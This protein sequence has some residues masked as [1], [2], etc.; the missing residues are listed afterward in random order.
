MG[1]GVSIG[2]V[3][4]NMFGIAGGVTFIWAGAN[5][6]GGFII[7][8]LNGSN[9]AIWQA[10]VAPD[11]QGRVFAVRRWIA[12]ITA[13]VGMLIAGPM[14]DWLME[15]AMAS[16]GWINWIFGWLVGSGPGTG[17]AV[18][19]VVTGLLGMFGGLAGYFFPAVRNAEDILPDHDTA[20]P[21][22]DH[23]QPSRVEQ[24]SRRTAKAAA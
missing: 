14:A 10:K 8:I 21:K 22:L 6:M 9:Q 5:F 1:L 12:Q 24:E 7:P 3:L 18:I 4:S 17:M 19:F 20:I 15:P 16:N 23:T 2:S 11:V 13:P